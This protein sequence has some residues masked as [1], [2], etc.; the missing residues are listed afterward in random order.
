M[1]QLIVPQT[2]AETPTGGGKKIF[3][4][5]PWIGTIDDVR[6]GGHPPFVDVAANPNAGYI[7]DD[8]ERMSLQLGSNEPMDGQDPVGN[9]K[10]FA[11][12]TTRDGDL[13]IEDV[14]VTEKDVP[15]WQ[16]QSSA[17]LLANLALALG[18]TET[19]TLPNGT[20]G[21]AVVEGF[22]QALQDGAFNGTRVG[23]EVYHRPW[24]SKDGTKSGVN[25][26]I[27]GFFAAV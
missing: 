21:V 1:A 12:F 11:E 3:P 2:Q 19:V 5:G 15:Y 20:T 8:G 25:V 24:T 13:S 9:L 22:L 4:A 27:R 16:L 17:R 10:Y 14:D 6:L 26:N 18:Q 23:F 7:A